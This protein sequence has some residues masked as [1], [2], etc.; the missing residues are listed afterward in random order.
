MPE[1]QKGS[2]KYII[3]QLFSPSN[4]LEDSKNL[5][6]RALIPYDYNIGLQIREFDVNFHKNNLKEG[7][8]KNQNLTWLRWTATNKIW[9]LNLYP[10]TMYF[11][12]IYIWNVQNKLKAVKIIYFKCFF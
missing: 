3:S 7:T 9:N 1:I 5:F 10:I 12:D 8:L 2:T 4:A 6:K 11:Q